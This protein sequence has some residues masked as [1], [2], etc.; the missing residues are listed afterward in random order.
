GVMSQAPKLLG[1]EVAQ[2][3]LALSER[4]GTY[5][6]QFVRANERREADDSSRPLLDPARDLEELTVFSPDGEFAVGSGA[7][8][9]P[10]LSSVTERTRSI[11]LADAPAGMATAA[12]AARR[13]AMSERTLARHLA[14]EG[15]SFRKLRDE[16]RQGFALEWIRVG[17]PISKVADELGFSDV[18][19]FHRAFRRWTGESPSRFKR[20]LP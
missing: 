3:D 16:V 14:T 11:L 12:H 17:E 15:T 13:L 10:Q 6:L 5:R 9:E 20:K 7:S 4:R 18:A 1:W 2:I 8:R 19:A